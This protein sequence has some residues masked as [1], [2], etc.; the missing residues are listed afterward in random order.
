[1]RAS[2]DSRAT[3]S[4]ALVTNVWR[5]PGEG[6]SCY[7]GLAKGILNDGAALVASET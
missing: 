4:R 6:V 7:S 5:S 1:M 2:D 3:D